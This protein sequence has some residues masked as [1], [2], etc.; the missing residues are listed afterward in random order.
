[1]QAQ[2]LHLYTAYDAIFYALGRVEGA[3]RANAWLATLCLAT[4]FAFVRRLGSPLAAFALL[5]A[6]GLNP[7]FVWASR[8]TLTEMLALWLNL[9]GL[10]LLVLAW[11]FASVAA[12]ALAGAAFGL[13]VLNR[14]DGGLGSFA[15]LGFAVA[16]VLAERSQRRVA[17]AAA[18]G[19]LATSAFAYRD[20]YQL[21]PVYCRSLAEGSN[22][23]TALPVVTSA[24]D[25]L[26]L[27]CALAPAR[28]VRALRVN[29]TRVRFVSYAAAWAGVLWIAYGLLVR[30]LVNT[31]EEA[32]SLREL[33][34][35]VGW[36]AWPLF[37]LGLGLAL[38]ASTFQRSLP[39]VAFALGT[40]AIYTSRTD[41][42]P[43]HIWAS[44][45]WVP[46]VIPLVLAC[47]ALAFAWLAPR[48]RSQRS[49]I[50]G[51]G[52]LALLAL[53][54]PVD[55]TR[56]FLFKSMLGGL[57]ER[58]ERVASYARHHGVSSP[59]LTERVNYGSILTY[60]YDVPTALLSGPGAEAFTRGDFAGELAL[61]YHAFDLKR[62]VEEPGDYFGLDLEHSS[63]HR[64]S[65]VG[66]IRLP[67]ELGRAG[68]RVFVAEMPAS[69]PNL[70][71]HV[72]Q[73]KSDGSVASDGKRGQLLFGPWMTLLP[74][75]YRIEWYGRVAQIGKRWRQGTLDVIFDAGNES[76]VEAPIAVSRAK[77][78]LLG[79]L[80]FGLEKPIEGLEFRVRVEAQASV[81]VTKLRLERFGD[82]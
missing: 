40:L 49:S 71:T 6:L 22:S 50:L 13:G 26:A 65:D 19:H 3:V 48:L 44:R 45:R 14:L 18:L 59:L 24:L 66:E 69:H 41:V 63:A 52:G 11:D 5:V 30:P 73:L 1:L 39:L 36:A 35:Y 70:R 82:P 37:A 79:A 80:D 20:A 53:A 47:A 34:W 8:I 54:S 25:L 38:R 60:V 31:G 81:A 7:A 62:T 56:L 74:G 17:I 27:G 75:R 21:S 55:F 9:T 61:G 68:P 4:G 72:G 12:G 51:A 64:P 58:Y 32:R 29:E 78:D 33:T 42:A 23:V 57:A 46:H 77:G 76:I 2:F 10:L 16:S 15:V 67:F 43:V 28:L